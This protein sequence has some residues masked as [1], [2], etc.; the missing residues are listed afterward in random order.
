MGM[1]GE[2]ENGKVVVMG[3]AEI[4]TR[5]PFKSVKEAVLLFGERVLVK[6]IY[7]YKLKEVIYFFFFNLSQVPVIICFFISLICLVIKSIQLI[8]LYG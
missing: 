1:K 4:D 8:N 2:E 7:G 5:P 3:R 6:E